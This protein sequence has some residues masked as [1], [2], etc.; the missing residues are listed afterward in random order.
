MV[1][2]EE[3]CVYFCGNSLGLCPKKTK[4]YMNIELDK[5]AKKGVQGH[6]RGDLPWAWCDECLDSQMAELVVTIG[7]KG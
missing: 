3:D 5:W 2:P 6:T 7:L 4:E 1:D